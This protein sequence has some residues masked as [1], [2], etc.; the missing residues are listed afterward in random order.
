MVGDVRNGQAMDSQKHMQRQ[1]NRLRTPGDQHG[2]SSSDSLEDNVL[3]LKLTRGDEIIEIEW[4]NGKL[5]VAPIYTFAGRTTRLRNVSDC[6]DRIGKAPDFRRAARRARREQRLQPSSSPVQALAA[7]T[8]YDA[9]ENGLP[10]GFTRSLPW[11]P[12]EL[13]DKTLLKLCYCKTLLWR[14]GIT[15]EVMEDTVLRGVNFDKV[16]YKVRHSSNGRRIIMF[17]GFE[18][19]R[20]VGV[21][22]LLQVR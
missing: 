22:A 16:K 19:F 3:R 10:A 9:P 14:N 18:G 8:G 7:A 17:V 1:A 15:G 13:D 4:D 12:D 20:A 6:I 11:D 2:W 5:L 21:D